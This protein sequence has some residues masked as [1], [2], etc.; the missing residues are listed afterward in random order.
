MP[1]EWKRSLEEYHYDVS[2]QHY[3]N[4]N[5]Y[6][7]WFRGSIPIN[8]R[9]NTVS[10]ENHFRQRAL[11]SIEAWLEVVF[12][13][14]Y[15]QPNRRNNVTNQV[16]DYFQA[17]RILPQNLFNACDAY[18]HND[19]RDN[20]NAIRIALGFTSPAIAVAATFPAF[21]RPDLFPM[22]DTRIAKWVGQN[23]DAHNTADPNAPQLV[24]PRYLDT[25]ATV[26]TLTDFDFVFSWTRWCKYKAN[27]LNALTS[28][29]WRP[30]D[31]E[32]AV[33]RAWGN[34]NEPHPMIQLEVLL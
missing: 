15:S 14:M 8:D 31:V 6:P 5:Q 12:W 25:Q 20:L 32:M 16:A 3:D 11:T 33:F 9:H 30:R 2:L 26:L 24:R 34:R 10:F 7:E 4:A 27:Q 29:D 18:I 1:N 19:T 17:N 13:K 21:L 28:I 23:M 22:V